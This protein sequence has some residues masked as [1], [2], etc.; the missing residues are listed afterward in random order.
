MMDTS[1]FNK[2]KKLIYDI[3]TKERV[4]QSEWHYGE[5]NEVVSTK[6]LSVFV[7]GSTQAQNIPCNPDVTFNVGDSV[8]VHFLNKDSKN[9]FV[10]YKRGV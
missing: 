8:F 3:L 7:D 5:V 2:L 10:P 1:N 6:T 9:K 4:F